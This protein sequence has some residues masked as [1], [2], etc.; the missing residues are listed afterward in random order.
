M[1]TSTVWIWTQNEN[2]LVSRCLS[3]GSASS[4]HYG[5]LRLYTSAIRSAK[6]LIGVHSGRTEPRPR[7][8]NVTRL[9]VGA[10]LN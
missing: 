3:P 7:L 10:Y 9:T 8:P 4:G 5:H 2:S 6:N 1:R